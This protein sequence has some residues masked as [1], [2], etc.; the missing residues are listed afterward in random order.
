[1]LPVQAGHGLPGPDPGTQAQG[2][3]GQRQVSHHGGHKGHHGG[4]QGHYGDHDHHGGHHGHYGGRLGHHYSMI[5]RG[6]Q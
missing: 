1:M 3:Q 6:R 5:F 2:R 4:H